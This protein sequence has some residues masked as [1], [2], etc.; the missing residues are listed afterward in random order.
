MKLK[1]RKPT[2]RFSASLNTFA[3]SIIRESGLI[4]IRYW[5][6]YKVEAGIAYATQV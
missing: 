5:K 6:V 2:K 4:A 1:N 3:G